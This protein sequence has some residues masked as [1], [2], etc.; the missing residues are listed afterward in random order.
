LPD[1]HTELPTVV[2]D[3]CEKEI[4]PHAADVDERARYPDEALAAM[5]AASLAAVHIPQ[6]RPCRAGALRGV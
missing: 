1:E 3:L 2:R 5:S 4:A 6:L